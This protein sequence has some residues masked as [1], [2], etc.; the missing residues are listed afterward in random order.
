MASRLRSML[1][2]DVRTS[3]DASGTIN[4]IDP[5]DGV[6]VT[7]DNAAGKSTTL[8]ILPLFFGNIASDISVS[9]GS[10]LPMLQ[11]VL[12]NPT[13]AFVFEYQRGPTDDDINCVVLRRGERSNSAAY[14]FF[15]GPFRREFFATLRADGQEELSDDFAFVNLATQGGVTPSQIFST[16]QYRSIILGV[17]STTL[18]EPKLKVMGR[19]YSYAERALP[20]L[21]RLVNAVVKEK[22]DFRD[23]IGVA[24]SIIQSRLGK[25]QTTGS[26]APNRITLN[27]SSR[28]ISLWLNNVDA[29]K[30]VERMEPVLLDLER[31]LAQTAPL[32]RTRTQLAA[33]LK[34]LRA[35]RSVQIKDLEVDSEQLTSKREVAVATEQV[36]SMEFVTNA[37]NSRSNRR[38]AQREWQDD[39]DRLDHFVKTEAEASV[40]A[41]AAMPS[42]QNDRGN[43]TH[44]IELAS[45]EATKLATQCTNFINAALQTRDIEKTALQLQINQRNAC[46]T[47]EVTAILDAQKTAREVQQCEAATPIAVNKALQDDLIGKV[48]VARERLNSPAVP[49]EIVAAVETTGTAHLLATQRLG[50]TKLAEE[51]AAQAQR[52]ASEKYAA[53]ERQLDLAAKAE[54]EAAHQVSL[55]QAL[56]VPAQGSVLAALRASGNTDWTDN[57]ARII[58]P[59]LLGA[60]DL[61][62]QF[63]GAPGRVSSLQDA[64]PQLDTAYGWSLDTVQID[65]PDWID[66]TE[67]RNQLEMWHAKVRAAAEKVAE[68]RRAVQVTGVLRSALV[69]QAAIAT[70]DT[71]TAKE[72]ERSAKLASEHALNARVV[73]SKSAVQL[74]KDELDRWTVQQAVS[75]AEGGQLAQKLTKALETIAEQCRVRQKEAS[76]RTQKDLSALSGLHTDCDSRFSKQEKALHAQRDR[77]T[78]EAGVSVAILDALT[79]EI[80]V[81]D[82]KLLALQARMPTVSS[83]TVWLAG[84]GRTR[85]AE[86]HHAYDVAKDGDEAAQVAVDTFEKSVRASALAHDKRVAL[87]KVDFDTATVELQILDTVASVLVNDISNTCPSDDLSD[88]A[89]DLLLAARRYAADVAENTDAM[90]AHVAALKKALTS[91]SSAV[92]EFITN[93]VG[94]MASAPFTEQ[95]EKLKLAIGEVKRAVLS[96]ITEEFRTVMTTMLMFE[97]DVRDFDLAVRRFNSDLQAGMKQVSKF[98]SVQNFDVRI[99]TNL[100]TVGFWSDLTALRSSQM[101]R[102]AGG[103][104][105]IP[106]DDEAVAAMRK[107][108]TMLEKDGRLEFD[109]FQHISL[110][111]SAVINGQVKLFN[112]ESD[113]AAM[114]SNGLNLIIVVSL[115]S[116]MFNTL[117]GSDSIYVPW[118][119]DEIGRLDGKNFLSMIQMLKDNHIDVVTASPFLNIAQLRHFSRR[120]LV[121]SNGTIARFVPEAKTQRQ[122]PGVVP[123]AIVTAM[124]T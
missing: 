17:A 14:R 92:S 77:A 60:I 75:I 90:E 56:L 99:T 10:R 49:K 46:A 68:C 70:A 85:L 30:Q 120:Y 91:D 19:E 115:L 117:R 36:R 110:A 4:E 54:N 1:L 97:K 40:L 18:V 94:S 63:V 122:L 26:T 6:A 107:V 34:K 45:G 47:A 119:T 24:V 9:G 53:A 48:A 112:R 109:M 29:C 16:S 41:V 51:A 44:Q 82:A 101:G 108:Q 80:A 25:R 43:V 64:M 37:E 71:A 124:E 84:G 116:G 104:A 69:H 114:S 121:E 50:V 27:Q 3:A 87:L 83:W 28:Q 13:S 39:Q 52:E 118:V 96:N 42:L 88:S 62:P 76:E 61:N 73:A 78:T 100:E 55:A 93:H 111:G 72:K 65:R 103:F 12:V 86:L 2:I 7:G 11:Y 67:L 79:A 113:L 58:R 31:C 8:Q 89:A 95:A 59:E 21:D 57:L 20:N 22:V 15:K 38:D 98:D 81:I 35:D 66:A 123:V 33:N 23:F 32:S 102:N 5:R 74:A 105:E 106:L